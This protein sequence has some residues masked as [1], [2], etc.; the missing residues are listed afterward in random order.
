MGIQLDTIYV[1]PVLVEA[2]TDA[3]SLGTVSATNNLGVTVTV[4]VI[5]LTVSKWG[6]K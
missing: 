1:G 3:F 4:T 5:E 2:T 6:N